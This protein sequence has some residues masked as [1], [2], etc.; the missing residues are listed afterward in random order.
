MSSAFRIFD[1]F[2]FFDVHGIKEN[3]RMIR[4][5][6]FVDFSTA[7]HSSNEFGSVQALNE[8]FVFEKKNIL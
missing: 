2:E 4:V 5:I 6:N 1:F 7:R 3:I 8:K